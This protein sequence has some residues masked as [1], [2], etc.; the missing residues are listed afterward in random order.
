MPAELENIRRAIKR[1]HPGMSKSRSF[2]IATSAFKKK[3]GICGKTTEEEMAAKAKEAGMGRRSGHPQKLWKG[4]PVDSHIPT[5]VL[6]KINA[7]P[8][9]NTRSSCEGHDSSRGAYLIFRLDPDKDEK[10]WDVS[11]KLREQGVYSLADYGQGEG[12]PRIVAAAGMRYGQKGWES[13]WNGLP[14]KISTAVKSVE[15][16]GQQKT[17]S[18]IASRGWQNGRETLSVKRKSERRETMNKEAQPRFGGGSYAAGPGGICTCTSCGHEVRH[19]PGQA[20]RGMKCPKCGA[21][22]ARKGFEK[23]SAFN[24]GFFDELEKISFY[25]RTEKPVRG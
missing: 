5:K 2:A 3:H 22:M 4:I 20:C 1:E 13:W 21:P 23:V 7:I 12:R 14:G 18:S 24:E 25:I 10:A 19:A 6:D 11:K 17:A 15:G 16:L 8:G 9:V